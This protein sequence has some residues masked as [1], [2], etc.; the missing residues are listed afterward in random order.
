VN[1]DLSNNQQAFQAALSK[2]EFKNPMGANVKLD[3]NRQA[4]SDVFMNRI[5]ERGGQLRTV[6][7][8]R[9][10]A[11]TQT[12]GIDRE[13]FMALGAPSRDNPGCVARSG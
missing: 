10:P 13:K 8:Q 4:I 5:E 6:T 1:G 9:T 2:T 11:V 7:F 12:L 3:E